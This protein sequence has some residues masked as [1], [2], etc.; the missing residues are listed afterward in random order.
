MSYM[1]IVISVGLCVKNS[2]ATI[3]ETVESVINQDFPHE[4]MEIIAVDGR[5]ED[6]TLSIMTNILLETDI[7]VK[8]CSDQGKGLGAA[9]QLVVNS[10]S[11]E[12]IIWIDGDVVLPKN[13]VR[14][15]VEFMRRNPRVGAALGEWGIS[16]AKSLVAVLENLGELRHKHEDKNPRAI[17][18]II[19]IYRVKAIKQAGSFDECIK[20]ASEDRDL[21]HRIWKNGWLL[22]R[23]QATLYH[24]FREAWNDL[25]KEYSWY[26]YGEH[27]VSHKHPNLVM[28]WQWLP[29]VRAL[30]GLRHAFIVYKL[31]HLKISFL[32]PLHHFFKAS[33]F[34]FG[35]LKGHMEGYGHK[36][37]NSRKNE[38]MSLKIEI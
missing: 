26:G 20:G 29:I 38:S 2:E 4:L 36:I 19:G 21:S 12:Y 13:Y 30:S 5:S 1:K 37:D 3:R 10:A 25:W 7:N 9:R 33:A 11:G 23:N 27:Y 18:T 24:R 28:M 35:F 32:L 34:C 14:K 16:E 17:G 6:K 31:T 22:A 8:L 15:H